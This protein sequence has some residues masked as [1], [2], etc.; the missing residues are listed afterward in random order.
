MIDLTCLVTTYMLDKDQIFK[1]I[2]SMNVFCPVILRNQCKSNN[3][4]EFMYNGFHIKVVNSTDK[5]LSINRNN[6]LRLCNSEYLIF[7][8]DD[9]HFSLQAREIIE[10][11]F[12]YK[13]NADAFAFNYKMSN[14]DRQYKIYKGKT[15]KAHFSN[16]T[17]SGVLRF[18]FRRQSINSVFDEL[19]GSGTKYLCG[20][21]TVFVKD[22]FR[23]KKNDVYISEKFLGQIDQINSVWFA[24]IDSDEYLICKSYVYKKI[25]PIL[26]W[27]FGLRFLFKKR[28]FTM[29]NL[30]LIIKGYRL[31][32]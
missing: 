23:N 1:L 27:I 28:K 5:G 26:Y 14:P 4:Y 8:D 18:V 3:T 31:I 11:S 20:E 19:I 32:K 12:K 2:A 24:K 25:Y 30:K 29:H 17:S 16:F 22:Y 6:L 21:D 9:V 7:C 10:H 13:P 15:K